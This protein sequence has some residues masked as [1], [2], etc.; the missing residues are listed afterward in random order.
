MSLVHKWCPVRWDLQ[1]C[2]Q[3]RFNHTL[4]SNWCIIFSTLTSLFV[5]FSLLHCLYLADTKRKVEQISEEL[6]NL[7][8]I[9]SKDDKNKGLQD[10]KTDEDPAVH[11]DEPPISESET[12][13]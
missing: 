10:E 5:S 1:R 8:E 4:F 3:P 12:K 7:D 9:L 6:K 13:G 11:S 2:N